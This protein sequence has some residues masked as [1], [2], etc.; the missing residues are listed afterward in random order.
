MEDKYF[1][2]ARGQEW[3]DH[4]FMELAKHVATA[5]R[6]PSTRSGAVI[7]RP[8]KTVASLGYNGFPRGIADD[9]ARYA[10]RDV[11]Y[12]M[13]IHSE[14]NAILNHAGERLR[15]YTLFQYPFIPCDR[16]CVHVIQ[17]GI[18]RVVAPAMETHPERWRAQ[19]Q[20]ALDLFEEAGVEFK[21]YVGFH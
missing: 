16:C 6:D 8:D 17:A 2:F 13:V 10:D 9:P 11:K 18:T 1:S 14:M 21:S 4:Y 12:S 5:S 15:G 19:M 3:W 7:V 20:I